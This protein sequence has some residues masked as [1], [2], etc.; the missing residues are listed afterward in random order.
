MSLSS[1]VP[2]ALCGK[3]QVMAT[4]FSSSMEKEGYEVVHTCNDIDS[5]KS[6][7]PSLLSSSSGP[8]AVVIGKG[9]YESEMQEI[10]EHCKSEAKSAKTVWLLPDD[11]KFSAY[12]KLKAVASAG[13]MLP[14]MIAER[15][16][17]ALRENG[18]VAGGSLEGVKSGVHG[19]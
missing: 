15:A 9:F 14:G 10:I 4:N 3:S 6:T 12:M 8:V 17:D 11:D 5:A 1:P 19:F 7:L 13:T 2:I 16:A 18:V